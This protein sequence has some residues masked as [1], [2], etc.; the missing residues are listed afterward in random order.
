MNRWSTVSKVQS[1]E[2]RQSNTGVRSHQEFPVNGA[3]LSVDSVI[4]KTIQSTVARPNIV[5]SVIPATFN[6]SIN[7]NL[8][9]PIVQ[10]ENYALSNVRSRCL[11]GERPR[12]VQAVLL[13]QRQPNTTFVGQNVSY[14]GFPSKN[15]LAIPVGRIENTYSNISVNRPQLAT[16]PICIRPPT[17]P[18]QF[19]NTPQRF[20]F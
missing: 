10:N 11:V 7:N 20:S 9:R 5:S 8:A 3:P 2:L 12:P 13:P 19:Q 14:A 18:L 17:S 16:S 1:S 4:N 15:N 6:P